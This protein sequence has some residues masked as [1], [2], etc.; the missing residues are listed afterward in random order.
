MRVSAALAAV[1]T[2]A[3]C[4]PDP[5]DRIVARE[6]VPRG[7]PE[8]RHILEEEQRWRYSFDRVPC[9]ILKSDAAARYRSSCA[10]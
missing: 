9:A 3:A 8:Y 10:R 4:G 5:K 1:L 7:E 6:P 2:L